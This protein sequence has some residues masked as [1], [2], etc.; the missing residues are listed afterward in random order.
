ELTRGN[1]NLLRLILGEE[2][3]VSEA[4]SVEVIDTHL[5]DWNPEGFP[6][7]SEQLFGA[8]ALDVALIPMQMKKGRP[9]FLLR[10]IAA[11]PAALDLKQLILSE[12][13]AIGLR[14]RTEQRLTLPRQPG[15][16]A[17]PWGRVKVKRVETPAGPVLTPEYEDCRRLARDNRVVLRQVY[18]A[19]QRCTPAEFRKEEG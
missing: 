1:P 3:R 10:V 5:D 6:Y 9:G 8:G 2:R 15:T 7:L 19:V 16:V 12:T 4:Q 18:A 11:E 14:F 13:T 17:T